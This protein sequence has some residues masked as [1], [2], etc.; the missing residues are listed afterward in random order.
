ME[1]HKK[2]TKRKEIGKAQI[3]LRVGGLEIHTIPL[4]VGGFGRN[5][6]TRGVGGLQRYNIILRVG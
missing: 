4:R 3:T 5:K 6:T 1:R 2:T